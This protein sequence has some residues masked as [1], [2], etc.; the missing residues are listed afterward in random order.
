MGGNAGSMAVESKPAKFVF[1]L[2]R[3]LGLSLLI[4]GFRSVL[5]GTAGTA[6][7]A[8]AWSVSFVHAAVIIFVVVFV[9][10]CRRLSELNTT[11]LS[12]CLMRFDSL[13]WATFNLVQK[14]GLKNQ[15]CL[16]SKIT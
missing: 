1:K 5:A 9:A 10:V 13:F 15:H 8:R 2:A 14:L 6:G 4:T 16:G 12:T 3:H 7:R 11:L